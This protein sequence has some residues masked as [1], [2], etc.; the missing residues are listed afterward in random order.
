MN[1]TDAVMIFDPQ[2]P[3]LP[4]LKAQFDN[5][6]ERLNFP[7]LWHRN[8]ITLAVG[9]FERQIIDHPTCVDRCELAVAGLEHAREIHA[10]WPRGWDVSLSYALTCHETNEV[11]ATASGCSF[12][13]RQLG[14]NPVGQS[15]RQ[16]DGRIHLVDMFQRQPYGVF[17][18]PTAAEIDGRVYEMVLAGR[19]DGQNVVQL[20]GR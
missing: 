17:V 20:L 8:C 4:N 15:R 16:D 19:W 9:L 10:T 2:T 1:S 6:H 12:V 14:L 18:T 5:E 3:S 13:R 7:E 11:W